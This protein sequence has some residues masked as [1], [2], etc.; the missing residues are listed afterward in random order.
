MNKAFA[1]SMKPWVLRRFDSPSISR[2][3]R[4]RRD[5]QRPILHEGR[6]AAFGKALATAKSQGPT[7]DKRTNENQS[8]QTTNLRSF[9]DHGSSR[10]WAQR[11]KAS[12]LLV[13]RNGTDD[14]S[15]NGDCFTFFDR[16]VDGFD[17]F[18]IAKSFFTRYTIGSILSDA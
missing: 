13:C 11:E 5:P 2:R 6:G 4:E 1:S 15:T 7:S 14:F 12:F 9:V 17:Y 18:Q 16:S 3:R 10:K 8:L